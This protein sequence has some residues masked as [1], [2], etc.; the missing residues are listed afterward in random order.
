MPDIIGLGVDEARTLLRQ[1]QIFIGNIKYIESFNLEKDVIIES[2]IP[3]GD[4]IPAGSTVD[5]IAT[6]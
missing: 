4:K 6:K 3:L 1:N 5:I 2:S